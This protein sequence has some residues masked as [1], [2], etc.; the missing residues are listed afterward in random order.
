MQ[1]KGYLARS[2]ISG[3]I[4][5]KCRQSGLDPVSAQFADIPFTGDPAVAIV[6]VFRLSFFFFFFLFNAMHAASLPTW[7]P[8]P[9]CQMQ[10]G[11][12]GE[13]AGNHG[14]FHSTGILASLRSVPVCVA[15]WPVTSRPSSDVFL[16]CQC[17]NSTL[18][19]V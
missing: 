12:R 2:I 8:L 5:L 9:T 7:P 14:T 16:P 11:A 3:T 6:D 15:G 4:L 1:N 13:H 10:R 18:G 19:Q 17:S